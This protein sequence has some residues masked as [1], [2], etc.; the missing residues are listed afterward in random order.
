MSSLRDSY[1]M[2]SGNRGFILRSATD[3]GI[4]GGDD[5]AN[6]NGSIIPVKFWVQPEINEIFELVF[7]SIEISDS[8]N[9]GLDDYGSIVG[10]LTNGIQFFVEVNGFEVTFG[11]PIKSNRELVNLGPISQQLS[12]SGSTKI[13][14]HSFNILDHAPQ[15]AAVKLNGSTNDKFGFIV[16]DNLLSLLEHTLTIK[17]SSLIKTI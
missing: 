8:G 9:P 5:K 15:T 2:I 13:T 12:F 10:P 14:T 1:S 4:V 7:A 6:V 16:Q 11:E 17:G 3:N